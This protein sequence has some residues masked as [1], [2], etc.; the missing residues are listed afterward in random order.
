MSR[1]KKSLSYTIISIILFDLFIYLSI[2][3]IIGQPFELVPF[4]VSNFMIIGLIA[5]PV[6]LIYFNILYISKK[7]KQ[8]DNSNE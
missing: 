6:Y 8:K 4:I 3:F 1:V 7:Y 2:Y 5:F